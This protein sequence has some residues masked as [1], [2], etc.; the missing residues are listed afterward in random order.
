[1]KR[2][3]TVFLSLVVGISIHAQE[4]IKP[5]EGELF[6]GA[7]FP[8][9]AFQDGNKGV[10]PLI[11]GEIRYNFKESPFDIG[12]S[13]G[14]TTAMYDFTLQDYS[15]K[16]TKEYSQSNRTAYIALSSNYN[17]K[18]GE[19]INPYAGI[20]IGLASNDVLGDV[21]YENNEGG[22]TV[23]IPRIGIEFVRHFRITL[24]ST[25]S[26]KGYHNKSLGIGFVFGGGKK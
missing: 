8:L 7:T 25:I 20:G 19:K 9:S 18:Q 3:L 12:I 23:I 22:S 16:E 11:G 5:V 13:L 4:K 14:M 6:F 15:T 17:F 2:I 26:K 24:S 1:M 21:L 10:G